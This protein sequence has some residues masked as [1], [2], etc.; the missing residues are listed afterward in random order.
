MGIFRSFCAHTFLDE[1][2]R[3][4]ISYAAIQKKNVAIIDRQ[5]NMLLEKNELKFKMPKANSL[6][7]PT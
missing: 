2:Q 7:F 6:L 3:T 4:F 5:L 1:L